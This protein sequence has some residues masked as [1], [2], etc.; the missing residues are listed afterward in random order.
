MRSVSNNVHTKRLVYTFRIE[1][2]LWKLQTKRTENN[3]LS[4][5][6]MNKTKNIYF[7]LPPH[8]YLN[9]MLFQIIFKET[10]RLCLLL[11]ITNKSLWHRTQYLIIRIVDIFMMLRWCNT[12]NC[13]TLASICALVKSNIPSSNRSQ[14]RI[15]TYFLWLS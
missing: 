4:A 2:K 6:P 14:A 5:S 9:V 8:W 1:I 12:I 3:D 10:T 13:T 7:T 11:C 15:I